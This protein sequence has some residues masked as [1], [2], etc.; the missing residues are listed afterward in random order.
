MNN[1]TTRGD[2]P[3]D[4]WTETT[5]GKFWDQVSR[6]PRFEPLYFSKIVA[7]PL[8]HLVRLFVQ[9]RQARGIDE[10][11][12]LDYGCGPGFLTDALVRAGLNVAAMEFSAESVE[13]VNRRLDGTGPGT[14]LGSTCARQLPTPIQSNSF[15]VVI[16]TEAYE[17]LRDEW[18]VGYFAEL[19]R[20]CKPDGWI[21]V[22]TP[23]QE[24]L[25][26]NLCLCPN[27]DTLF[28]RWGHL[29]SVTEQSISNHAR[30]GGLNVC[31]TSAIKIDSVGR[32]TSLKQAIRSLAHCS[33]ISSTRWAGRRARSLW[34]S[35]TGNPAW[36]RELDLVERGP[37]L[38]MV[39]KPSGDC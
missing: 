12:V 15:D 37:H 5:I 32:E 6:Q 14:F 28:H 4:L 24:N 13:A 1:S 8:T 31:W 3:E 39:A 35:L 19:G 9:E 26:D 38:V 36:Q 20:I 11:T 22:T 18:I 10:P 21:L 25:D 29:R 27:C 16:S 7:A 30:Q 23:H 2:V 17:H 34:Q 33:L